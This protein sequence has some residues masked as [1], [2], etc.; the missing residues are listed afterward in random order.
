M[1]LTDHQRQAL[2]AYEALALAHPELFT[3]RTARPI[4]RD[5]KVLEAYAAE[6]NVVLG[7]SA[8]TSHALFVVDLVESREHDGSTVRYPYLRVVFRGQLRGAVNVVVLATIANPSL[9]NP[10]DIILVAQERHALGTVELELPRGFGEPGVSG[11]QNAFRELFEETG[12]IGEEA[13]FLG[14][15]S[16]DSGL[17]GSLVSFYHVPAVRL[18]APQQE[19]SEVIH[20]VSLLRV[21]QAWEKIQRGELRD[22]LTVQ[23]LALY[24]KFAQ[25]GRR[26]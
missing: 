21:S 18:E 14:V 10:G 6:N 1:R 9:G 2:S 24:E 26:Y 23:A 12:Y 5:R 11:E 15:T 19:V 17:T 7:V 3:G 4:V 13:H 22:G 25:E 16:P 8:E 20:G